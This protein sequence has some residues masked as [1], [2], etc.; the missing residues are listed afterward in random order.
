MDFM[1][2]S[3][4]IGS[5]GHSATVILDCPHNVV[6]PVN[7]FQVD[8]D[9]FGSRVLLFGRSERINLL[10]LLL[11]LLCFLAT[12]SVSFHFQM[13]KLGVSSEEGLNGV[14]LFC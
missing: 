14:V 2:G 11:L 8:R 5:L 12:F 6:Q 3:E 1:L 9:D 10:L 4:L 7:L 13:N